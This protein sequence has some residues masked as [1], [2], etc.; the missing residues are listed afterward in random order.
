M[1]GAIIQIKGV[2]TYLTFN[3]KVDSIDT[4]FEDLPL[5]PLFLIPLIFLAIPLIEIAVF[6]AVGSR[7]GVFPTVGLVILSGIAGSVLLRI[8]G[9]GIM[10]RIRRE[11]DAG[12]APGRE[13]AHGAMIILAGVLLIIPGFV[14]D[15]FGLLLF[16]PP[17]RD[18]AWRFLRSRIQIVSTFTTGRG[19]FR[20][21]D[22]GKTIDLDADDYSKGD[23]GKS[24]WRIGG[25]D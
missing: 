17:V 21:P 22:D 4:C 9:F 25:R 16:I 15:I 3:V 23:D 14:S 10:A 19:G 8:Q 5:L 18:L 11:T 12:R 24:P 6:V 2:H 13:M 1:H 20:R 7:I